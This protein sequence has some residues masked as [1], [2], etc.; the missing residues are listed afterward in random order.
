MQETTQVAPDSDQETSSKLT[1]KAYE[2]ELRK[3]QSELCHLQ[4]GV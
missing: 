1:R 3:L 4:D 2:K